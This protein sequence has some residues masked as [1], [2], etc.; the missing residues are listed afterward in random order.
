MNQL[1]EGYKEIRTVDLTEDKK[2]FI[3]IDIF[4]FIIFIAMAV[5]GAII[6]Q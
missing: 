2:T 4:S 6:K 5:L 3:V 1:P